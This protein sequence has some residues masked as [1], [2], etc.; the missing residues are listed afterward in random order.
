MFNANEMLLCGAKCCST[1]CDAV[2]VYVQG[3]QQ[4]LTHTQSFVTLVYC[5]Y[6]HQY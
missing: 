3:S 1:I 5:S 4:W 6:I 2:F